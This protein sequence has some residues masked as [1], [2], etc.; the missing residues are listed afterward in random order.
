MLRTKPDGER[1]V[2][3][4]P[5]PGGSL[6]GAQLLVKQL[7]LALQGMPGS[8]LYASVIVCLLKSGTQRDTTASFGLT[9]HMCPTGLDRL[10]VQKRAEQGKPEPPQ[11]ERD[12]SKHTGM[13]CGIST[14]LAITL[15]HS[16]SQNRL[17]P[18][19]CPTANPSAR[20]HCAAAKRIKLFAA[21][22]EEGE[23]D[24]AQ[25]SGETANREATGDI[26]RPAQPRQFRG[27]RI[28][29]PSRPGAQPFAT[30]H[31][32][33]SLC[34]CSSCRTECL[35]PAAVIAASGCNQR[36]DAVQVA[37]TRKLRRPSQTGSE[38]ASGTASW[39]PP[40]GGGTA[41]TAAAGTTVIADTATAAMATGT[42]SCLPHLKVSGDCL[43]ES[44]EHVQRI[45]ANA[46]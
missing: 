30:I 37:S 33:G 5:A 24:E 26:R 31:R 35:A 6:L 45:R 23:E 40:R 29:T 28:E 46:C 17:A 32:N 21:A 3:K 13:D 27:Q 11:G 16:C 25:Q 12:L 14:T 44:E 34:S 38:S 39:R 19:S 43:T 18:S 1:H 36:C 9:V 8:M 41:A 20:M 15:L 4:A 2:F 22:A 42:L 10:A 7:A